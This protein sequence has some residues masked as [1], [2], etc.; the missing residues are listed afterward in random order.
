[1]QNVQEQ[2]VYVKDFTTEGIKLP[3]YISSDMLNCFTLGREN[4]KKINLCFPIHCNAKLSIEMKLVYIN[5]FSFR[6]DIL[7]DI[8]ALKPFLVT[9]NTI[10][11]N[12]NKVKVTVLTILQA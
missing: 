1:M 5:V 8:V 2:V 10:F 3:F 11:K 9:D 6:K 4:Q 7:R 12:T